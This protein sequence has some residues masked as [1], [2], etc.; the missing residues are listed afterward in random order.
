MTI[1]TMSMPSARRATDGSRGALLVERV[2]AVGF[3]LGA[4]E[5][6]TGAVLLAFGVAI[7]PPSYPWWR[8]VAMAVVDAAVVWIAIRRPTLLI[9]A[10]GAFLIEQLVVNGPFVWREATEGRVEWGALATIGFVVGILVRIWVE[11]RSS[12]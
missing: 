10:L 12:R 11:R 8:H 5:H 1:A 3:S 2:V 9:P 7:F 6:V 4:L